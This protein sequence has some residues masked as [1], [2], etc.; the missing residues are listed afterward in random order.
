M[1]SRMLLTEMAKLSLA[2]IH[3]PK[4]HRRRIRTTNLLERLNREIKRRAD[5]MQIFSDS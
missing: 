4:K 2:C 5:V 3:F 1:A